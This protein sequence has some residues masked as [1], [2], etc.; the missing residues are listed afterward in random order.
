[1]TVQETI[2]HLMKELQEEYNMGILFITHDLGV[3]AEL[4]DEVVVMYKGK[5]VEK[6]PALQIFSSP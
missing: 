2:L 5:I 3:I 1:M 6:G 4:A